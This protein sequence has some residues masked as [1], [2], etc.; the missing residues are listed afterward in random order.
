[1]PGSPPPRSPAIKEKPTKRFPRWAGLRKHHTWITQ[2]K[3]NT[4]GSK[5]KA[6]IPKPRVYLAGKISQHGWRELL[7]DGPVV[8]RDELNPRETKDF[9]NFTLTGPFFVSTGH[10]CAHGPTAHGQ[11]ELGPRD[12]VR[13]RVFDAN[14]ARIEKSDLVFAHINELDCYGTLFELGYAHSLGV[15]VFLNFG[16]GLKE[17]DKKELWFP[18]MACVAVTGSV[19]EAFNKALKVWS[20]AAALAGGR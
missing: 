17:R 10:G 3:T 8:V 18:R 16:I 14:V 4:F 19:E 20:D 5:I 12:T 15:P 9:W 1:M 2:M 6:Q 13:R 11:G 7:T